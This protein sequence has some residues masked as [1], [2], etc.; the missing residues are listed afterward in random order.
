[1]GRSGQAREAGEDPTSIMAKL[2]SREWDQGGQTSEKGLGWTG[3][4]SSEQ[5]LLWW[6]TIRCTEAGMSF[7]E[8]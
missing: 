8:G 7:S 4:H 3:E 5:S 6:G 2:G 1:L